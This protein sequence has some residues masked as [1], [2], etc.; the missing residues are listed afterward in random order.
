MGF[1]AFM[2]GQAVAMGWK[3]ARLAALYAL[4]L[5]LADRFLAFALFGGELLSASGLG[6]AYLALGGI[7]LASWRLTHVARMIGQ[8]PWLYERDGAWRYRSR[9]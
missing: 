7:A 4:L 5:T 8:Y 1:A 3:P 2:T 6:I 9:G